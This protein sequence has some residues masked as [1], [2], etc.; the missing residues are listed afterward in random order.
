MGDGGRRVSEDLGGRLRI[1][2]LEFEA[3]DLLLSGASLD[4]E[5]IAPED[6]SDSCCSLN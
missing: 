1:K 3:S 2:R 4:I 5:R 6:F